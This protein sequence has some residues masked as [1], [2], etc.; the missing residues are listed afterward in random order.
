MEENGTTVM[1]VDDEESIRAVLCRRL[2]SLGYDCEEAA[3][4]EQALWKA[5]MHDF[6]L[7]LMDVRMPKMSGMDVLPRMVVD[8]PETSVLMLTAVADVG[9]AV[10]AMKLGA[11]DYVTK[12]FDMDDVLVRV[13]RALERRRLLLE[14]KAH[15]ERLEQRVERQIGQIHQCHTEAAEALVREQAAREELEALRQSRRGIIQKFSEMVV[16]TTDD[17]ARDATAT[18]Q[19]ER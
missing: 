7:V 9:T 18:T 3:D 1:V 10:E 17:P 5:F 19:N 4:G 15:Q 13:D 11:C 8:H 14:N 12:P 16:G 6:D 2:Q